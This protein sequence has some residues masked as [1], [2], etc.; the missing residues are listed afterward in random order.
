MY[1]FVLIPFENKRSK[2]RSFSRR[3]LGVLVGCF[4]S[5]CGYKPLLKGFMNR[6]SYVCK[7]INQTVPRNEYE[8]ISMCHAKEK[9]FCCSKHSFRLIYKSAENKR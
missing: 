7:W 8:K 3:S 6:S 2:R 5:I 1:I 4:S 9:L